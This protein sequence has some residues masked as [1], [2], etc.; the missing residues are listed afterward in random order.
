MTNEKEVAQY[1]LR[2]RV[3]AGVSGWE[4]GFYGVGRRLWERGFWVRRGGEDKALGRVMVRRQ[5][6]R[7]LWV[8]ME[9]K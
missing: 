5:R 6:E 8:G 3:I 4:A 9:N 2:K 1:G 7:S